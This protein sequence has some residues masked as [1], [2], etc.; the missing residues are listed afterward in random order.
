M[1]CKPVCQMCNRLVLSQAVAF[2]TAGQLEI[3][4]PAGSYNNGEKY[5]IVVAQAIPATTTITAP[6]VISIG[7]GAATYPLTKRNCQ[8]VTACGLR[9]RTRYSVCIVTSATGG[10]FRM[11]GCPSCA[12]N[13]CCLRV[14]A[15]SKS[16]TTQAGRSSVLLPARECR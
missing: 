7:T 12:P 6:V 16:P 11:L 3:N 5:C 13:S 2:N 14:S 9:T 1:G 4:L 10:T 15:G 8:Q